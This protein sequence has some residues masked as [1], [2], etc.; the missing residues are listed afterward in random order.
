MTDKEILTSMVQEC[1]SDYEAHESEDGSAV[2]TIRV[3]K[4]FVN[5]WLVKLSNLRTTLREIE[6]FE[7][8]EE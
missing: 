8:T 1:V 3:P 2:I 4:R 5:L 7:N 6:E